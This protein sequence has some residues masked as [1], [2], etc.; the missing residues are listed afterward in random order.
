MDGFVLIGICF[1]ESNAGAYNRANLFG[2]T[3]GIGEEAYDYG[4]KIVIDA[5]ICCGIASSIVEAKS[6]IQNDDND[7]YVQAAKMIGHL[8]I[9]LTFDKIDLSANYTSY[10]TA[11]ANAANWRKCY[12]AHIFERENYAFYYYSKQQLLNLLDE[13]IISICS[14]ITERE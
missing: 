13:K 4:E 2:S 8:E 7:F 14:I 11:Y 3:Q 5:M 10:C 6:I 12:N 1:G 9:G